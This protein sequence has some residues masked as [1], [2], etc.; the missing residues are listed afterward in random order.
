[1]MTPMSQGSSRERDQPWAGLF[2]P[3]GADGESV[4]GSTIAEF[5][6]FWL[7]F[8]SFQIMQTMQSDVDV[9]GA[10]VRG[11]VQGKER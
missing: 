7:V 6:C 4:G 3:I 1:M 8:I 11:W 9:G 2:R 10:F 5:R